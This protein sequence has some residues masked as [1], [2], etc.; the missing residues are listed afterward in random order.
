MITTS[1]CFCTIGITVL[2]TVLETWKYGSGR[3]GL[4]MISSGCTIITC[5][6]GT[7]SFWICLHLHS[8]LFSLSIQ[9]D[10]TVTYG[11]RTPDLSLPVVFVTVSLCTVIEFESLFI[12]LFKPSLMIIYL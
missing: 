8:L 10:R 3:E 2:V 5:F 4:T 12:L 11:T 1:L 6:Y 7:S 9:G